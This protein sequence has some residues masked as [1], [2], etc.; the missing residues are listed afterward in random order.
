MI[1]PA[2]L[3]QSNGQNLQSPI[4]FT[5]RIQARTIFIK[6]GFLT[7]DTKYVNQ[8][9]RFDLPY[10]DKQSPFSPSVFVKTL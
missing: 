10:D 4:I 3:P 1:H 2:C 5:S 6:I 9:S 8:M 7:L